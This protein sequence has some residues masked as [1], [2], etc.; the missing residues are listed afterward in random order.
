[1]NNLTISILGN[2]I[3]SEIANE[4]K[5]FS[6]YKI[7]FYNNLGLF[8]NNSTNKNQLIIFFFNSEN[9]QDY[10]KIV[11]NKFPIIIITKSP[12]LKNTFIGDFVEILNM[13][14]TALDLEKK[15]ISLL[16]R[17]EFNKSSLINLGGYI[18]DKNERKIKKNELELQL[19]EREIDFL[20]LFSKNNKA[21]TRNFFLKNVWNYSTES[22][23]HTIETHIHRLRKKILEK[24]KD[25]NF[26]KNN[27]KGYYI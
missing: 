5:L 6:K 27:K 19:T 17:Y 4:L 16:A 23:T 12:E 20:I 8:T 2:K 22:D 1:M 18:I 3:F 25:S 15:I 21:L 24:F 7:K 13:P 10:E 14:F 9:K 26:I 11:K